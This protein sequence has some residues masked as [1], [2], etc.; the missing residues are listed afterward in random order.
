MPSP[1]SVLSSLV[2]TFGDCRCFWRVL[3][4]PASRR[5]RSLDGWTEIGPL[6]VVA[7]SKGQIRRMIAMESQR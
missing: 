2:G 4:S 7:A 5:S 6:R 1:A 3:P